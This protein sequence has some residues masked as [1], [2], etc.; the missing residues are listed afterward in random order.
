LI[1]QT[2]INIIDQLTTK[3]EAEKAK[4]TGNAEYQSHLQ[5]DIIRLVKE[6]KDLVK[7]KKDLEDVEAKNKA[8][9]DKEISDLKTERDARAPNTI[10]SIA[11]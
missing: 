4:N 3:L 10:L 2:Q 5:T 9:R 8:L 11:D 7:Q 1:F 6:R